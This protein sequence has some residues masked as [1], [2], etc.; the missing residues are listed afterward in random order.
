MR[1]KHIT[2]FSFGVILVVTFILFAIFYPMYMG[3]KWEPQT[4]MGY[5]GGMVGAA[6]VV[7]SFLIFSKLLPQF[8]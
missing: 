4:K 1:N 8:F 5:R 3:T 2:A 7:T 6:T